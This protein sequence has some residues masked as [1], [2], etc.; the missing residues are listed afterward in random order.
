M[1][2]RRFLR[3]TYTI[4][5]LSVDDVSYCDTLEDKIR[6]YNKDGD[7]DDAGEQKVYGETAI[8]YG[9]YRVIVSHSPKFGRKLPLLM[10]VPHFDG[11][12]IHGGVSAVNTYGCI[13]LGEN[14]IKG[15]LINSKPYVDE[16]TNWIELWQKNKEETW[17]TIL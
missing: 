1:L 3:D 7:L 4:G 9:R 8:P 14:K 16:L 5:R 17:I 15:G 6:D 2:Q 13:L 10:D 12:R 11:I